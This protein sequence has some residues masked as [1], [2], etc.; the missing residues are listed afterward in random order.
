MAVI[1]GKAIAAA[2][3][4]QLSEDVGLMMK[5]APDFKP[6]LAIVQVMLAQMNWLIRADNN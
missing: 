6:G 4:K 1:D 2:L 5:Q 3:R